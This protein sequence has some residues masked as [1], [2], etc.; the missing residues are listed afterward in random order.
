MKT[1]KCLSDLDQERRIGDNV[2]VILFN[3]IGTDTWFI[4]VWEKGDLR[5]SG[6]ITFFDSDKYG[7][8]GQDVDRKEYDHLPAMSKE[9]S[10]AYIEAREKRRKVEMDLATKAFP[11]LVIERRYGMLNVMGFKKKAVK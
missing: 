10:N 7:Q 3:I 9:R 5:K 6:T 1:V 11:E 4:N 8:V 2:V